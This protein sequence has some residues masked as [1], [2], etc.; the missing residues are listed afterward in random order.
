[1]WTQTLSAP[2]TFE[3]LEVEAP[4][5]ADLQPG[6]VLL[7]TTAGAICGSDLPNFR[8]A[9]FPHPRNL[10]GR[11]TRVPGFPMHEV[12]GQVVAS[13]HPAHETGDLVV[14]WASGFD[15]IAELVVSDGEGLAR[16]DTSLPATTAVMLQPLACVLYAA[17]QLGDLRGKTVAVIGQGP[18]GLLFSHI[19]KN[20][21]ARHVTGV[22][23]IDRSELASTF[24]VDEAVTASA[25]LWAAGLTDA[26]RPHVVVEAVGH[27]VSTMK[28]CLDSVAFGGEIFYF[29]VPD[30]HVYPFDMMTLLRKNLTLRAGVTLERRRVL[31][32]AGT[33]LAANPG[34][35]DA[36]VSDVYH[37]GDIQ[38]AFDAASSPRHG[39]YKIAVS[40]A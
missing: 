2:F 33:Y 5:P 3:K 17:E 23:R 12:V 16:Y 7:A 35:R 38:A 28:N 14:G 34:L 31:E 27:Q 30:D 36:Y 19:L 6:Q 10:G 21:G 11:V 29:G 39:Q 4:D 8:G 25:A 32:D 20:R 40:M 15:A 18:I 22:D 1:M 9:P 13:R 26:D 24:G 37:V